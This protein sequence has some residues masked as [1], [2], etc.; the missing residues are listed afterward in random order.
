MTC[1]KCTQNAQFLRPKDKLAK[2]S[3][4]HLHFT[5][6][7]VNYIRLLN[8]D[9]YCGNKINDT[10]CLETIHGLNGSRYHCRL[11]LSLPL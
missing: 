5:T 3:F 9:Q 7:I 2:Q 1:T 6:L 10:F 4:E 8:N 11:L